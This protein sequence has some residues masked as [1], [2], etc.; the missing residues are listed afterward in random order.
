MDGVS[1]RQGLSDSRST[2]SLARSL[3]RHARR[4]YRIRVDDAEDL[5]QSTFTTYLESGDRRPDVSNLDAWLFGIFRL[6]CLEHI[7]RSVRE[8]RKLRRMCDK[9]DVSREN[10]WIRPSRAGEAPGVLETLIRDEERR[11]IRQALA[12]LR[13]AHQ[14][15]VALIVDDGVSRQALIEMTGLNRNTLDSRLHVCRGELRKRL[16]ERKL[17]TLGRRDRRSEVASIGAA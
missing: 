10:P 14:A 2:A 16:H 5:V 7:D 4:R 13:P 3:V 8:R 11:L 17:H 9:P 6:K 15:L 12:S 1:L